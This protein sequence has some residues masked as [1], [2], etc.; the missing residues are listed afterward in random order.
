MVI[1][2][3]PAYN[4]EDN[5][6]TLL[7]NTGK[8]MSI[9]GNNYKTLVVNDGSNDNTAEIVKSF[10]STLPV[11]LINFT[12]HKGVGEAFRQGFQSALAQAKDTDIIVTKEADNTSDLSIL[13][14]MIKKIYQGYDL[15]LASCYAPGGGLERTSWDR[16]ILSMG[17]SFLIKL[18]F[19]V[20]VYT[21]SS[22]YRAYKVTF[23]KKAFESYGTELIKED[24]FVCMVE[25]LIKLHRLGAKIIEVPMVLRGDLRKGKSKIKRIKTTLGYFRLIAREAWK[26]NRL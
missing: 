10:A 8:M 1:F 11:E 9:L 4:E 23:L 18:F 21:S 20:K 15:A 26:R 12:E 19:P 6:A 25:L 16:V 3:I 2:I 17:A 22:F 14:E 5:I 13:N 7:I 24:G